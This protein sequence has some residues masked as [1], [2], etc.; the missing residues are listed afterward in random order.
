M[1]NA[2]PREPHLAPGP[3]AEK[4][5]LAAGMTLVA[6]HAPDDYERWLAPLPERATV[7]RRPLPR[8]LLVHLFVARRTDLA[9]ELGSWRERL[10]PSGSLWVSW[11]KRAARITS[12]LTEDVVREL[13]LPL[14]FVDVKVCSVSEVWSGLKLV[15]RRELREH[16]GK[17]HSYR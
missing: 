2:G 13:A 6:L 8:P 5:G 11:P 9:R 3:L 17:R 10:H 1:G 7:V 14:G 4:L 12:D 16:D 15:I